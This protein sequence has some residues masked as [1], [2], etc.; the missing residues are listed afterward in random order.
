MNLNTLIDSLATHLIREFTGRIRGF[1]RSSRSF[2]VKNFLALP[3]RIRVEETRLSIDFASSPLNA[4]IH[5]SR[6]DDPVEQVSWLAGRR[7]EFEP[8]G[9]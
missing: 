4:V 2:V 8:Y 7:I 9:L 5:L 1:G 3:G 6:L